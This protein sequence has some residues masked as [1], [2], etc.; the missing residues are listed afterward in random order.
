MRT[1]M[2]GLLALFASFAVAGCGDSTT[3]PAD[4]A[5][6]TASDTAERHGE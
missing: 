1:S 4:A 6:D 3:S 5:A 2:I